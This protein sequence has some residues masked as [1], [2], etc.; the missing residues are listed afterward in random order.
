MLG[1]AGLY[2][3]IFKIWLVNPIP[4]QN[5][6][7]SSIELSDVIASGSQHVQIYV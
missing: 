6:F 7:S 1:N 3:K 4:L 5:A 2:T